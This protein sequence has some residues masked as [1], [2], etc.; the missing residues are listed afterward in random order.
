MKKLA[1]QLI[2]LRS[3]QKPKQVLT[4][5]AL[6]GFAFLLISFK[7]LSQITIHAVN[8]PIE[9]IFKTIEKQSDYVFFYKSN[10][11]NIKVTVDAI[12]APVK[13]EER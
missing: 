6:L 8:A 11:K 7:A 5:V 4:T 13:K 2:W 10:L 12:N 1:T 3:L 9:T